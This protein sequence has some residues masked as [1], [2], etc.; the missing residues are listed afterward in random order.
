MDKIKIDIPNVLSEFKKSITNGNLSKSSSEPVEDVDIGNINNETKIEQTN[1]SNTQ[2]DLTNI[3][4]GYNIEN[5]DLKTYQASLEKELELYQT[6]LEDTE[7]ELGILKEDAFAESGTNLTVIENMCKDYENT[8]TSEIYQL[9]E[10][11]KISCPEEELEKL[12]LNQADVTSMTYAELFEVLKEEDDEVKEKLASIEEYR[13]ENLD[14]AISENTEF[15]T[16]DE[17]LARIEELEV[18]QTTLNTSIYKIEQLKKMAKYEFLVKEEDYQNFNYEFQ[19]DKSIIDE[20]RMQM[21]TQVSYS[22]YC[23][24]TGDNISPLEF[25]MWVQENYP[26]T[27]ATAM[28]NEGLLKTLISVADEDSDLIKTYNYL[29]EKEGIDSAN[30]YLEDI[31]D[32]INQLAGQKKAEKFLEGLKKD[33]NGNYDYT[34]IM[35]HFKV[36]GKGIGDGAQNFFLGLAA[37]HQSSDVYSVE[38][39]ESLYILEALSDDK[40]FANFLDNNYEISMSVGN[41]LPSMALGML[42]TPTA[43]T[44]L[45]GTSAGGNS[46]HQALVN[47]V[48]TRDAVFYGTL[49]GLSEATLQKWIGSIP[50]LN[51][52]NV[53]SFKELATSILKEGGE[54]GAQEYIDAYL[55]GTVLG[56]QLDGDQLNLDAL[57]STIYGM[58]ISGTM[59]GPSLTVNK[60]SNVESISDTNISENQDVIETTNDVVD[61]IS[62]INTSI[63]QEN[64]NNRVADKVSKS[65]KGINIPGISA[66]S[67]II[68]GISV[69]KEQVPISREID[70]IHG[71]QLNEND[72]TGFYKSRL[73][74][75]FFTKEQLDSMIENINNK[76]F[77]SEETGEYISNL[78]EDPNYDVY[79]KTIPSSDIASISEIGLYCNNHTASGGGAPTSIDEINIDATI[80][81]MDSII[82][83]IRDVKNA[84]GISQGSNIVDGAIFLKIP[85]GLQIEDLVY[86][87]EEKN[88]YCIKPEYIDSFFS[89]DKDGVVSDVNKINSSYNENVDNV[90]KSIAQ[91]TTSITDELLE[92]DIRA[93][94]AS[95]TEADDA[96][97]W[98]A[99]KVK[100]VFYKAL[101]G[102][103][104]KSYI[105]SIVDDVNIID[106]NEWESFVKKRGH[107]SSVLGF[108]DKNHNVYFPSNS[109]MHNVIHELFHKFSEVRNKKIKT[110]KGTEIQASG[111]IELYSDGTNNILSN[112][113]LTD[114]LAS[115]YY[116]QKIYYYNY[117]DVGIRLWERI[118][119][120]LYELYGENDILLDSYLNNDPDTIR[121]IFDRYVYDG[122]Y[123]ELSKELGRFF[124]NS[125]ISGLVSQFEKA[126]NPMGIKERVYSI[127]NN[128]S[129]NEQHENI[130]NN[131]KEAS[132]NKENEESG[133][134][135]L[136]NPRT[137][138]NLD[139]LFNDISER[140]GKEN[141][142][143]YLEDYI[144][145]GDK[146]TLA[147]ST[148]ILF[149]KFDGLNTADMKRYLL[150]KGYISEKTMIDYW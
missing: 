119:N 98:D 125:K 123:T 9:I 43:G 59:N 8:I 117:D 84:N 133:S 95:A 49:S 64:I 2:I 44:F 104:K 127:F 33:E 148:F 52:V 149:K 37:W 102:K 110:S 24:K 91:S 140:C 22:E 78:F 25:C 39:Y 145:T 13:K 34:D 68:K 96:D 71:Y 19:I 55:R 118:D 65:I 41:M 132:S 150:M 143:K 58:I 6:M 32:Q 129:S 16:Y 135:I 12:G 111:I 26:D 75:G 136:M 23:T 122:A 107:S 89:V 99:K 51:D 74:S 87:N 130:D 70:E 128:T 17:Y 38:E 10:G 28:D 77:I 57:K 94:M 53:T 35:N 92:S 79:I 82:D 50:G 81:R 67:K 80:T 126:I 144:K 3:D 76:G 7:N 73:E 124:G 48:S 1:T 90:A 63:L 109:S 101:K 31:E 120:A 62:S 15:S 121:S 45:M 29:Y 134:F 69:G 106:A 93:L 11:Y 5:T 147:T 27:T 100:N 14:K 116:D 61:S 85:K 36:S 47:G 113:C 42:T 105:D 30:K 112:E 141:A 18:Q 66:I 115:K 142:I 146:N 131:I 108:V 4:K 54:E 72:I 20:M 86:F 60:L 88:V 139:N 103:F 138:R 97:I 114:Y 56:E 21:G 46:Y 40:D 137:Y 83:A